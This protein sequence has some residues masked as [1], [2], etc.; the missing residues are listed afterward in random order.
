MRKI[1]ILVVLA[2]ALL[3]L[4]SGSASQANSLCVKTGLRIFGEPWLAHHFCVPCPDG[5]CPGLPVPQDLD[6]QL[7]PEHLPVVPVTL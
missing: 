5:D 4:L 3:G 7:D 1:A 6:L 2:M